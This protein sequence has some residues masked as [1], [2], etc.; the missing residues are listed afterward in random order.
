[1]QFR[2]TVEEDIISIMKIINAAQTYF[3]EQ[4]IDQWQNGYPNYNSIEN[5]INNGYS[6][7]LDENDKIIGTAAVS[8]DGEKTYENIYNGA[9]ITNE[10]YAVVHRIAVDSNY[11]GQGIASIIIKN[12][13][14]L[15]INKGVHSIKIDTHK[16]NLS[17]QKLLQKN[18]FK[19]CGIIY[20]EDGNERIAF[21]KTF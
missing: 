1:M 13:E 14:D 21:E 11:K 10:E 20:L 7:V 19:Y 9:W 5:D 18:G 3:K 17:M 2:K 15:C 6:Y 16:E 8:F 4:G 12:I